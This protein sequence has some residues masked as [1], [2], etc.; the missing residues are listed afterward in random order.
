MT[1]VLCS[2]AINNNMVGVEIFYLDSD[3]ALDG[4]IRHL[5]ECKNYISDRGARWIHDTSRFPLERR[6][7]SHAHIWMSIL[8]NY[9]YATDF[10]ASQRCQ[11][12]EL[13]R[14]SVNRQYAFILKVEVKLDFPGS[15]TY[16]FPVVNVGSPNFLRFIR[17]G[18][19]GIEEFSIIKLFHIFDISTWLLIFGMI[20]T[21]ATILNQVVNNGLR[22][23]SILR[24]IFWVLKT[25][26]EQESPFPNIFIES[27]RHHC[28]T[29]TFLLVAIVISNAFKSSN[30]YSMILPRKIVPY[31]KLRELVNDKFVVYSRSG[32][33]RLSFIHLQN[34]TLES[35]HLQHKACWHMKG[36]SKW[37]RSSFRNIYLNFT[38][39]KK[40]K[41]FRPKMALCW[42]MPVITN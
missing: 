32:N 22:L 36:Q 18:R 14:G 20:C 9:T 28:I 13:V 31:G 17:C 6:A 12:G 39:S 19:R 15:E 37:E 29:G 24:V 11:N 21:V 10:T 26:L 40:I 3:L 30:V 4:T 7:H 34:D 33:I 1:T 8:R 42:G 41:I 2:S 25:L 5:L 23:Q 35:S 27:E 38:K 16:F